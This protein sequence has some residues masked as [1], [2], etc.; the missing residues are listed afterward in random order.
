[1]VG[2]AFSYL[3]Q[4][5]VGRALGPEGYGAFG[6]LFAI[7]YLI[8][9][10]SGTVQTGSARFVSRLKAGGDDERVGAFLYGLMKKSVLLGVAGFALFCIVSSAIAGFLRMDSTAEIL[11]LGTVILF[12]FLM[13][14]ASGVLQGLQEFYLL[15]FT[16]ILSLG[17]KLVFGLVLV[18][19]GY[20]VAGALGAVTLA[21][22][23]ALLFALLSLRSY[24][25]DG[26]QNGYDF[27]ELYIYS[28][29]TLLVMLCLAVPSNVDVILAKHFFNAQEAGLYTAASVIGKII[30]F[31]P[32]AISVVMFPKV[33]E[34][35]SQGGSTLRLL[36][37]SLLYT[38]LLSGGAAA[39][40][41]LV[42]GLVGAIFGPLYLKAS[43]IIAFYA[44]TMAL[45]SMTWVV[46]QYCL[47]TG[48][49]RYT[50]IL[51][52]L[53]AL[54]LGAIGLIHGST[55]EMAGALAGANL[56]LFLFSYS[57]VLLG[58]GRRE[59]C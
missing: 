26:R 38:G 14:A 10:F 27:R 7:F 35:M 54:E 17:L 49:L 16:G 41:I 25:G 6:S 42:P 22:L 52:G 39:V 13:P 56:V 53:T 31:L 34:M 28:A 40:F 20:G 12:S 4:I 57:Y 45:F 30:L 23:V 8:S 58:V 37:I 36:N 29:P 11:V 21:T 1:M 5:Y 55:L 59:Q 33:T 9:I 3:Y 50:Y 19:L 51:A 32:G 2:C 24:L 44:V 15:A 46:A 18:T 48:S 47:A 43:P